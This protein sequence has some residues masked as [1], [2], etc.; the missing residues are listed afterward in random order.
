MPKTQVET[1]RQ[2]EGSSRAEL[3]AT[4]AQL[5]TEFDLKV[6]VV[7]LTGTGVLGGRG[8]GLGVSHPDFVEI[9]Q[10]LYFTGN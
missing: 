7:H 6:M 3:E 8:A 4:R 9:V 10:T 5:E 1:Q 2:L